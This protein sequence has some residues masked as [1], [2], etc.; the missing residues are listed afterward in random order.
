MYEKKNRIPAIRGPAGRRGAPRKYSCL[1]DP[2]EAQSATELDRKTLFRR[3][4]RIF[5]ISIF[6]IHFEINC[7][8]SSSTISQNYHIEAA[9]VT[10]IST[11]LLNCSNALPLSTY[12]QSELQTADHNNKTNDIPSV[13]L[14]AQL[15]VCVMYDPVQG[16]LNWHTNNYQCD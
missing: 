13:Y 6:I 10:F 1:R 7:R 9:I 12:N 4:S 11:Q 8:D 2:A 16:Q 14:P 15:L 3:P 5:I